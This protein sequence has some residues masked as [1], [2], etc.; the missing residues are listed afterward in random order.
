M[1]A[2]SCV[3]KTKGAIQS[4]D[5]ERLEIEEAG[6][7]ESPPELVYHSLYFAQASSV[8]EFDVATMFGDV[9]MG[10]FEDDLFQYIVY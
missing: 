4:D 3:L 2:A 6:H 9:E 5:H 10:L 1:M 8:F 7:V